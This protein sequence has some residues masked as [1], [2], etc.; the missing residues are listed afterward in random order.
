M[1]ETERANQV[2]EIIRSLQQ[3]EL[4]AEHAH[5]A[6]KILDWIEENSIGEREKY[7][8]IW[9][10]V[11]LFRLTVMRQEDGQFSITGAPGGRMRLS[12]EWDCPAR[13]FE[14]VEKSLGFELSEGVINVLKCFLGDHEIVT[15]SSGDRTAD[16]AKPE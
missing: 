7:T 9:I 2:L 5:T 10:D 15:R 1:T 3:T 14:I 16:T 4:L 12:F 11:A 8:E 6:E 13:S